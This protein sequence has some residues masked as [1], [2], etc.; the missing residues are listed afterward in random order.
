MLLLEAGLGLLL[1]DGIRA[2]LRLEGDTVEWVTDGVAAENA[3]VTDEF[4]LL[5][6]DIG[7]PRRSGLD[8]LRNLR[9]QGLLTPVLLLTARDKVADR[10][11]G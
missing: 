6:L 10:V 9:H 8:I 5:V 1:G 4:D 2:G 3:L 7:L 11:A